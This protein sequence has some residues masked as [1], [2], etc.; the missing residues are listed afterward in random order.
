MKQHFRN[1]G[2]QNIE[3]TIERIS[4]IFGILVNWFYLKNAENLADNVYLTRV[5][6][7]SLRFAPKSHWSLNL[8]VI[9]L[10]VTST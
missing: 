5:N 8:V 4:L 10:P 9:S 7:V 6:L 1:S 3:E 2:G